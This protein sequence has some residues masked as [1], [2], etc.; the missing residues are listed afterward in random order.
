MGHGG[1]WRVLDIEVEFARR[2][3]LQKLSTS[4]A[5]KFVETDLDFERWIAILLEDIK[6]GFFDEGN[7]LVGS[8]C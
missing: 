8:F 4:V 6:I 7:G 3:F 2:G 1:N 5:E